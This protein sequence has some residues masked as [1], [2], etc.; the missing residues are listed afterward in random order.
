MRLQLE[1]TARELADYMSNLSEE[2]YCAG[3][4]QGLEFEL[5]EAV[6]SGP[7]NYGRLQVSRHIEQLRRLSEAAGGWIVFDDRDEESLLPKEEW[8]KRF[9]EWRARR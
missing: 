6:V 4:M 3:W 5:W 1:P 2:A 8:E 7:R 9:N